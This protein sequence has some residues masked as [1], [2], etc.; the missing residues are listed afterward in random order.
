MIRSLYVRFVGITLCIMIFS[1]ILAFVISNVFYQTY[2]KPY[3]DQKIT[4]MLQHVQTY[5]HSFT[6]KQAEAYFHNVAALGY[7]MYLADGGGHGTF[8]GSPFR[9]KS[10]NLSIVQDVQS[11]TT[12][13]G[14]RQFSQKGF[15][16]GFF[17]DK[18]INSIGVPVTIDGKTY[19]LFMRPDIEK[20]FWEMRIFFALLLVGT[21]M[22]SMIFVTISTRYVVKPIRQFTQATQ[23]IAEGQYNIQ[24]DVNRSDEIGTLAKHFTQMAESLA[25][26]EEMRQEFVS[27]VS[28]EI[29][30]PLTSIQ[31]YSRILRTQSLDSKQRDHYLSIIEEESRRMSLLSKQMLTLASLDKEEHAVDKLPFDVGDQLRQVVKATEWQW[32]EKDLAIELDV[33]PASITGNKELLHQVWTNLITNSIKF[34]E[35]GGTLSIRTDT[36]NHAYVRIIIQDTGIGIAKQDLP[37]IFEPY[38]KADASRN[39]DKGGSGL[40]LAIAKKIVSLHGG[41]INVTSELGVGTRFTVDLPYF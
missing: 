40:G 9:D 31:G 8:Y 6:M 19:A 23:K 41:S 16:T 3:N 27:N 11:G 25:R 36:S 5:M 2:L 38:Y 28:H 15:V 29:Q 1:S 17:E 14:I 34:T 30:S 4:T 26:L 39:R 32:R 7:Q 37:R 12:Y 33:A 20:Q 24:L 10:I 18:L 21:V 22:L 35:S 13:H